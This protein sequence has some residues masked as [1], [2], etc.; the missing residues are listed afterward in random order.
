MWIGQSAGYNYPRANVLPKLGKW[1]Q[2]LDNVLSEKRIQVPKWAQRVCLISVEGSPNQWF[3]IGLCP[4][5]FSSI[6]KLLYQAVI[7]PTS[8]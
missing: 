7:I 2:Y 1:D 4:S 5:N 8:P 6:E 3:R